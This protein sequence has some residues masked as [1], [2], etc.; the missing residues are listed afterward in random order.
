[1]NE[2]TAKKGLRKLQRKG[3]TIRRGKKSQINTRW[4]VL[5]A[6]ETE[7]HKAQKMREIS[8]EKKK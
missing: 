1:M 8:D 7:G 3:D 4:I 5:A 6:E 2:K